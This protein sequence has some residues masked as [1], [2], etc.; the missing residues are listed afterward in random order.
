MSTYDRYMRAFSQAQFLLQSPDPQDRDEGY[1]WLMTVGI[2][3]APST[4]LK[5]RAFSDSMAA[6]APKEVGLRISSFPDDLPD[7]SA[8][9]DSDD[10]FSR[11]AVCFRWRNVSP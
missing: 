11:F 6:R 7:F 5:L 4:E 3:E 8:L 2:D 1:R 10:R 9:N